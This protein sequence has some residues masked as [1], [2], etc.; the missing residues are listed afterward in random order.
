MASPQVDIRDDFA[1]ASDQSDND[2]SLEKY[3]KKGRLVYLGSGEPRG[4]LALRESL[5]LVLGRE[6]DFE[7][8]E[9][10]QSLAE[11]RERSSIIH[12]RAP[13]FGP[14]GSLSWQEWF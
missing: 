11:A 4:G 5:A 6:P 10:A 13:S 8:I 3:L 7:V 9:Q 1:W 2:G 14:A 12:T